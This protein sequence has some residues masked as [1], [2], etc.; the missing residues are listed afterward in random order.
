VVFALPSCIT[1][2]E[3]SKIGHRIHCIQMVHWVLRTK[4][5]PGHINW[6]WKALELFWFP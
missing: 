4:A 3:V 2:V 1:S 5:I 6:T